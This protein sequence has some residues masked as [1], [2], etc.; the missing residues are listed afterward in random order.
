M[1]L[2]DLLKAFNQPG[3]QAAP[4]LII[5][6]ALWHQAVALREMQRGLQEFKDTID[7][8]VQDIDADLKLLRHDLDRNIRLTE[9]ITRHRRESIV[10]DR[11]SSLEKRR[12]DGP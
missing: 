10:E 12:A 3:V 7:K 6:I 4:L 8:V 11:L 5:V 1:D 2:L 9:A